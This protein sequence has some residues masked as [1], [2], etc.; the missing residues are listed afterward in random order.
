VGPYFQVMA[1]ATYCVMPSLHEPFGAATEPYLMGTPVVAHAT[2]GLLQQVTD[3]GRHPEQA[4][5]LLFRDNFAGSPR[6]QGRQWRQIQLETNPAARM[7]S[8]LY[9]SL[10]NGLAAALQQAR[11]LYRDRP[12]DYGRMLS[13]LYDQAR[14]FTWEKAAAEYSAIYDVASRP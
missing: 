1:G 11:D 5:G 8:A 14:K 6:E 4:T 12:E 10:V 2:G 7:H 13:R 9:V 3:Y